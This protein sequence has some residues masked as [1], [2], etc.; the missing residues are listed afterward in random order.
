MTVPSYSDLEVL[1]KLYARFPYLSGQPLTLRG[2]GGSAPSIGTIEEGEL[3]A[4]V[5]AS[6]DERPYPAAFPFLSEGENPAC[7]ATCRCN[8]SSP[9]RSRWWTSSGARGVRGW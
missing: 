2:S 6:D 3:L 7:H 9:G 8:P 4:F 5:L 1:E